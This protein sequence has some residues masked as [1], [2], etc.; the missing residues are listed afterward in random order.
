MTLKRLSDLPVG[1]KVVDYDTKYGG[2]SIVW[3]IVDKN[4][5]GYPDNTVTLISNKT[6]GQRR[7]DISSPY[8]KNSEIR[9]WLNNENGFKKGFSND[10]KNSLVDTNL[11][12]ESGYVL[13]KVFLASI[14]ELAFGGTPEK[15]F[16]I[17]KKGINAEAKNFRYAD[18]YWWTRTK[19][20]GKYVQMITSS[21]RLGQHPCDYDMTE[22][23]PLCNIKN[24][25]LV[26]DEPVDGAYKIIWNKPPTKPSSFNLPEKVISRTETDISWTKSTDP[27]NDPIS[28]KLERSLD[29]GDFVERYKGSFARYKDIIED[30]GHT[31]VVYRVTAIDSNGN[32]SESLTS[33]SIPV[34]DNTIPSIDTASA[35]LGKIT[36]PY[37]VSYK[38]VDPDEGQTWTVT[39]SLDGR[40][41]KTFTAKVGTSYTSKLSAG[42]W[43]KVLNGKHILKI[44]VVDSDGGKSAKEITFEKDVRK[45]DFMLDKKGLQGIDK[46]PERAILSMSASIP[47]GASI[48]IEITN[49]AL[50]DKPVWQDCTAQVLGNEKIFFANK[51]KTAT[52]W[53]VNVRVSAD[54]KTATEVLSVSSIGGFYD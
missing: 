26:K 54:K 34:S 31:S 10:F 53:A 21:D 12:T 27:E 25:V 13:D 52:Q 5:K 1:V 20:D 47:S 23:R 49:N 41:L 14:Y 6:L 33:A 45:L 8:Y 24:D 2:K 32:Q 19:G 37:S 18:E 48:K 44:E 7:F 4:Y 43:Q 17:F 36:T 38:V 11:D 3:R 30:K 22:V 29:G 35:D 28:Y 40:V 16:S 51:A 9:K 42:D 15:E 46:M 39:E 50:D